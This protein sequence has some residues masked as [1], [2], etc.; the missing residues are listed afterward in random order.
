MFININDSF[1]KT[2]HLFLFCQ[3]QKKKK[4]KTI[5][6]YLIEWFIV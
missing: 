6:L 3:Q 4:H 2:F 1:D 5:W